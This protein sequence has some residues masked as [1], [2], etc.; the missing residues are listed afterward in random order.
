M[1][2]AQD[3]VETEMDMMGI[4]DTEKDTENSK[5]D[6]MDTQQDTLVTKRTARTPNK[7]PWK[8]KR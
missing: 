3:T 2:P 5:Q 8:V 7:T 1:H 6:I 4:M